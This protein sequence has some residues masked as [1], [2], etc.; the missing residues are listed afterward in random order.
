[1]RVA[2]GVSSG[3]PTTSRL[4]ET[5]TSSQDAAVGVGGPESGLED[6]DDGP[7]AGDVAVRGQR[8]G[9]EDPSADVDPAAVIVPPCCALLAR[10]SSP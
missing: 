10:A 1:M 8:R 5:R 3:R 9:V 6:L 7:S 4:P 2:A